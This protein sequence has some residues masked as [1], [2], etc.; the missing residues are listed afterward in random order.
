MDKLEGAQKQLWLQRAN[1]VLVEK[2]RDLVEKEYRAGSTSLVR[3]NEAQRDLVSAQG[4]LALARIS[5]RQAW[6]DLWTATGAILE[7]VPEER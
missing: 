1:A 7:R 5:L 2:N 6:Y 4:Q 3:L